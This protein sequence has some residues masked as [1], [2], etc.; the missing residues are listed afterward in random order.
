MKA[1]HIKNLKDVKLEENVLQRKYGEVK[2][3]LAKVA[4]SS[5]DLAFFAG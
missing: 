4:M 3:K 2:V 5:T 1:W